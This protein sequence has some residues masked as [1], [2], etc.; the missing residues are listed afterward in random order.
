[1]KLDRFGAFN[2][3][4]WKFEGEIAGLIRVLGTE[5]CICS[6]VSSVILQYVAVSDYP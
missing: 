2:D 1:M 6:A 3:D 4:K 5:Y